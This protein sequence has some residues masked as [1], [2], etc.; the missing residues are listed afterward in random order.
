MLCK[1]IFG[2]KKLVLY[3]GLFVELNSFK[4]LQIILG[5]NITFNLNIIDLIFFGWYKMSTCQKQ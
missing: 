4:K 1:L 2:I 5:N 3:I